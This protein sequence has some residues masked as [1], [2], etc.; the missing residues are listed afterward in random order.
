MP[1]ID[2]DK[3]EG[4]LISLK[5]LH[6]HPANPRLPELRGKSSEREIIGELCSHGRVEPLCRAIADKGYFRNDRLIVVVDDRKY[7]V[8]E[9]NRRLCALKVLDNP[10]LA[11]EGM[12]KAFRR[13]AERAQL[14]KK[15][16]V[17]IVPSKFDAEVVMFSKHAGEQFTVGWDPLQQATFVAA[18][19]DQ[20]DSI[21]DLCAAYGLSR[22]EV[23]NGRAAVDVYRL[24]RLATLSSAARDLVDDPAKFP[25]STVFERLFRPKKSREAL[26]AEIS[27]NGLT[28]NSTE[29]KF[30]P[31]IGRILDDAASDKINTR[32][33]NTEAEQTAYVKSLRFSPGGGRFTAEEIEQRR[34]GEEPRAAASAAAP[35]P[36]KRSAA[37]PSTRLL[38][39]DVMVGHK[40]E[41]LIRL[42]NEGQRLSVQDFPHAAAFL[43]RTLLET[44]LIVRLKAQRL[45]GEAVK[46]AR[47]SRLG[48]TLAEMLEYVN[49]NPDK[50]HLD[51]NARHALEA[52]VS[53][54]VRQSKP[55]LDRITHVPEVITHLD[56]VIS[57][58]EQALP[59]LRE[60]LQLPK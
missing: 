35:A 32:K 51:P 59:L 38:P 28:I 56:E 10:D 37:K 60:L 31:V 22:E 27:E 18:K 30:L 48:P 50:L 39:R 24:A 44:A 17:E 53:R 8:Y 19:L 26:G 54:Q 12:Q 15:I 52:L 57:I 45:Y 23:I 20:G 7:I 11:P 42:V 29:E 14:P 21:A 13:L 47:S 25:Y 43:L 36:A 2:S 34:R 55:Q 46:I 49:R 58:R 33:L 5:Q 9:G 3:W 40:H 16:A 6:F 4:R 41:K 1:L